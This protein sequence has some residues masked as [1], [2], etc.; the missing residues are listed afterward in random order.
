MIIQRWE[1]PAAYKEHPDKAGKATGYNTH[2][3]DMAVLDIRNHGHKSWSISVLTESVIKSDGDSLYHIYKEIVKSMT[4][5]DAKRSGL[6]PSIDIKTSFR[7]YLRLKKVYKEDFD[8]EDERAAKASHSC[9]I[10]D[11]HQGSC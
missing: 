2:A 7:A 1:N 9:P 4:K 5:V 6:P 8:Y 3:P 11:E 10:E